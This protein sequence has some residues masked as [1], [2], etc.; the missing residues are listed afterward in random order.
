MVL[1]LSVH[2]FYTTK[3]INFNFSYCVCDLLGYRNDRIP[4][5]FLQI[6]KKLKTPI[7]YYSNI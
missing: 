4:Q 3:Y 5:Y 1:P 2:S 7:G 6:A